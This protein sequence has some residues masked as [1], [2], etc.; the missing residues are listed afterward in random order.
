MIAIKYQ[1]NIQTDIF[2]YLKEF[3]TAIRL[4]YNFS[5][6]KA[7]TNLSDIEKHLKK[8]NWNHLDATFIKMAVNEAKHLFGKEKVIFGSKAEFLK[9]K[10]KKT[11]DKINWINARNSSMLLRGDKSHK[12]NR[13]VKLDL[14]NDQILFKPNRNTEIKICIKHLSKQKKS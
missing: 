3:N 7:T 9:L 12:G 2:P 4:A 13:K 14:A 10:F 8:F 11:T 6:K 5:R 1:T